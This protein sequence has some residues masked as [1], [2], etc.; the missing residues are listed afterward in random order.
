MALGGRSGADEPGA[1]K[2]LRRKADPV[3]PAEREVRK[4]AKLVGSPWFE[5]P[6][7]G[8]GLSRLIAGALDAMAATGAQTDTGSGSLLP[9][10]HPLDL[11][12][13]AT[14]CVGHTQRVVLHSPSFVEEREHRVPIGFHAVAGSGTPSLAPLPELVFAARATSSFPGAFPP[15]LPGEIDAMM[16][17][18]G[19]PWPDATPFCAASCPITPLRAPSRKQ[20]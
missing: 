17:E 8:I 19:E 13:T 1:R 20:R 16:A 18:R 14:D 11:F 10:G 3:S 12:T 2:G 15:L 9:A 7:S 5:A 6:F 4:L